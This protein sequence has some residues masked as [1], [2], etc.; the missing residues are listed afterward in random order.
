MVHIFKMYSF[1]KGSLKTALSLVPAAIFPP[2]APLAIGIAAYNGGKTIIRTARELDGQ[3]AGEVYVEYFE[4]DHPVSVLGFL[5]DFIDTDYTGLR[6]KK[7][8]AHAVCRV[9]VGRN[10][11]WVFELGRSRSIKDAVVTPASQMVI[12]DKNG[13]LSNKYGELS[14]CFGSGAQ[15][16]KRGISPERDLSGCTYY[17][18]LDCRGDCG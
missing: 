8:I 5:P 17:R 15:R 4:M 6:E 7:K 13:D 2:C 14:S 9:F 18:G 16:H 11:S 1:F 10:H 12:A 3:T